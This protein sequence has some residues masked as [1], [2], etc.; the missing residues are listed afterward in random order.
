LVYYRLRSSSEIDWIK[1]RNLKYLRGYLDKEYIVG[2]EIAATVFA[3]V[4]SNPGI[5][6]AQIRS[7]VKEANSDDINALIAAEK[8][9]VDLSAA[10]LMEQ[11][12]VHIFRDSSTAKVYSIAV[13]SRTS[14]VTESL[15]VLNVK[16]GATMIW[17]G[18]GFTVTT[19][20]ETQIYLQGEDGLISLSYAEFDKLLHLGEIK[21]ISQE[22]AELSVSEKISEIFRQASPNALEEASRRYQILLPYLHGEP[23]FEETTSVR[24]IRFWKAKYNLA[25]EIYGCGLIGLIDGRSGNPTSRYSDKAW[26]LI[27]KIIEKHYET[28][29]EKNVW[30]VYEELKTAWS[31]AQK[32][33]EI[34]E[35]CPSH[36]TFYRR[37][38]KCAGY[39][40]TKKR[41]GSRAAN[42]NLPLC[43]QL[44]VTTPRHGDRHERDCSH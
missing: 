21:G 28:F 32:A 43:W 44:E 39:K 17:D 5:T 10:P 2:E 29:K 11:E 20:G 38:R 36:I 30:A 18:K 4:A 31:Q 1:S 37:I 19:K 22:E 16:A 40:Q 42:K 6:F 26:E 13:N 34:I 23:Q 41:L 24:T 8:I 7:E 14:T 33:G 35:D 9:Y 25:K 12:Q 3:V 15:Q 27:D